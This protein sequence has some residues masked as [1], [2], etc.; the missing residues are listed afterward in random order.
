[1]NF[2]MRKAILLG[3]IVFLSLVLNL[4][5]VQAQ[6]EL[7]VVDSSAQ[8]LFPLSIS[9]DLSAESNVDITDI[10]LHY[11][12]LRHSFADVTAETCMQFEP[13][14]TVEVSWDW[15]MRRTGGLPPGASVQYWWT[16][17]DASGD[18]I[19]TSPVILQ[20]DDER[21]SWQSL[22]QDMVTVHWYQGEQSFTEEIMLT[23]EDALDWLEADTGA[24]LLEPI[25][26]YLYA[27]SQ[28]LQGSMIFPQEWTGGVAFTRYGR[29]AIGINPDNLAWGKDALAHELTHLVVHQMTLSPYGGIPLW[30]DEGLATRS[31]GSFP[32]YY[33]A[34]LSQ[35]IA[36]DSLI[37][38]QSISSPFSAD[39]E[40]AI[41]S[42][43]ESYTVVDYLITTYGK[44]KM[45]ELLETFR[46]GAS[47]DGALIEVYG[48]DTSG[49]DQRWREYLLEP[50]GT[51]TLGVLSG[52]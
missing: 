34:A 6:A 43:A 20:F 40:L 15:D 7:T 9:F 37:S 24:V 1:M 36:N 48:F 25:E 12:V 51:I 18:Q 29:I 16:V 42:Y 2:S 11:R 47:Y 27:N 26:I 32:N 45:L 28:D 41:L 4:V 39:S 49:L 35:A 5:P 30:L 14:T 17:K 50:V 19:E 23:I 8:A 10:R 31:Q 22:T 44:D 38:V 13:A 52:N 3:V 21:F 33:I 46:A